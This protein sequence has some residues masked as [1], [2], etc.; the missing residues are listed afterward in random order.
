MDPLM[1][2]L[3]SLTLGYTDIIL[4]GDFNSNILVD[5]TLMDNLSAIGLL[6]INQTMPTHFT[7][8]SSTLLDLYFI[9]N[10]SRKLLYDQL[11]AST[12]SRHDLIFLSYDFEKTPNQHKIT[13]RDFKNVDLISLEND[14]F[15]IP[16]DQIFFMATVYEQVTK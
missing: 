16:W 15:N 14:I 8:T 5:K 2:E 3:S 12:F 1:N 7:S 11:S 6:I 4:T 10:L 9:G 13:Y